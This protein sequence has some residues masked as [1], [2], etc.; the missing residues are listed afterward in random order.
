MRWSGRPGASGRRRSRRRLISRLDWCG[1][2]AS[3]RSSVTAGAPNDAALLAWSRSCSPYDCTAFRLTLPVCCPRR[4]SASS[5]TIWNH[6][7]LSRCTTG[8]PHRSWRRRVMYPIDLLIFERAQRFGSFWVSISTTHAV[9]RRISPGSTPS[10][11]RLSAQD[12]ELPG[13]GD[14]HKAFNRRVSLANRVRPSIVSDK[15]ICRRRD[16]H[17]FCAQGFDWDVDYIRR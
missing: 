15:A 4:N 12:F 10:P 14:I 17:V 6:W 3:W 1:A 9:A 8:Y 2:P 16:A 13:I 7:F 5:F 11:R